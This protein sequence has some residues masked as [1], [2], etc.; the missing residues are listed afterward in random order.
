MNMLRDSLDFYTDISDDDATVLGLLQREING[1]V[2]FQ[3]IRRTLGIH[4]EKLSRILRRLERSGLV[5]R[6]GD[7]YTLSMKARQI[8]GEK[9]TVDNYN[10][11]VDMIVEE[12]GPLLAGVTSLRGRWAGDF[13]WLAYKVD[14]D[15]HLLEW[16]SSTKPVSLRLRLYGKRLIIETDARTPDDR[17]HALRGAFAI[18][19]KAYELALNNISDGNFRAM[20]LTPPSRFYWM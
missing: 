13:R 5:E 18:I 2:S 7:G 1:V 12:A 8:I 4:Q 14:D 15:G 20:W 6:V 3:G 17:Q 16:V 19:R 11:I 10:R 9:R